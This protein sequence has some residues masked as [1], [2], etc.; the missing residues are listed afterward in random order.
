MTSDRRPS[1]AGSDR[2][3]SAAGSDR[4]PTTAEAGLRVAV[5]LTALLALTALG[6]TG[7]LHPFPGLL[8]ALVAVVAAAVLPAA[9]GPRRPG[10]QTFAAAGLVLALPLT[11]AIVLDQ[12]GVALIAS[13]AAGAV[14]GLALEPPVPRAMLTRIWV[15]GAVLA[16]SSAGASGS[17][18]AVTCLV[19]GGVAFLT[20]LALWQRAAVEAGGSAPPRH[21]RDV[22]TARSRTSWLLGPVAAGLALALVAAWA[23]SR[24]PAP[25]GQGQS[26]LSGSPLG[27][28]AGASQADPD[29]RDTTTDPSRSSRD[30]QAYVGGDL[31][32]S[33]RGDLGNTPMFEVP[34]SPTTTLW[35]SSVQDHYEHGRWTSPEPDV[36]ITLPPG[37]HELGALAGDPALGAPGASDVGVFKAVSR[38]ARVPVLAPGVLTG[39]VTVGDTD[40]GDDGLSPAT[41]AAEDAPVSGY[42]VRW[43]QR[44][45]VSEVPA[46]APGAAASDAV[47]AVP[48]DVGRWTVVPEELP[49]RVLELGRRLV[50]SARAASTPEL[51]PS[52]AARAVEDHLRATATYSLDAPQPERGQ[53]PV[54]AFLFDTRV[55]F[56]EHF[57]SAEVLLLRAGGIPARL[58]TGFAVPGTAARTDGLQGRATVTSAMAHAWVEVYQPGLGWVSSDPTAGTQLTDTSALAGARH[59]LREH[60]LAVALGLAAAVAVALVVALVVR[61]LRRRARR[62]RAVSS[63]GHD[64]PG[65]R[66]LLAALARFEA[67]LAAGGRG[68]P[69]TETFAD[70]ASRLRAE[71]IVAREAVV[72]GALVPGA[73]AGAGLS[74]LP[75]AARDA[76]SPDLA[77]LDVLD[78]VP[79]ALDVVQRVVYGPGLP[80]EAELAGAAA[81]LDAA[82]RVV[83]G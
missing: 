16:L 44:L 64:G 75:G 24:L 26:W 21:E 29:G 68:R 31:D 46:D 49:A 83:R 56:C 36:R 45:D 22:V 3:P 54:D 51:L 48:P 81:A 66:D 77:T 40:L 39:I 65:R 34:G 7:M 70:L 80:G 32:L 62:P 79:A 41:W 15:N 73:G 11:C 1:A 13:L 72:H 9:A 59:W 25:Q 27:A 18:S 43:R 4:R 63:S 28:G 20:S 82:A 74:V 50:D 61:L 42:H 55:G 37:G 76:S 67:A 10:P 5:T 53:D 35:R 60:R 23:L 2:R 33:A 14:A 6:R 8:A 38:S 47:P 71:T 30:A 17:A 52:A 12:R 69:P 78:G 19:L 58:A 57:A